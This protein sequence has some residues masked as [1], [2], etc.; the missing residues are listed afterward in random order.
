MEIVL[1]ILILVV[2]FVLLIKG[3][4]ILV[5][6]ASSI[7]SN[8]KVSKMLIGL[9]IVAFGTSAPELAISISSLISGET[10]MLLG[11]VIGSNILNILLLIGVAALICPLV[12]R[13]ATV[14]KELP[15]LLLI[16]TALAVLFLDVVIDKANN[17]AITRSDGI[18]CILFF[19]IFLYYLIAMAK[20][21]KTKSKAKN[22][23]KTEEEKPKYN[24]WISILL[25]VGGLV[26]VI[27]GS[28]LV[29][30]SASNIATAIGISERVIAL[31][32]VAFGT[33]LPEL[34][35]TITAARR[36]EQDLI[37]GNII[38][39]NIFN[40]CV[41]LGIPVALFGTVTP[42]SFQT[43]DLIMFIGSAVLLFLFARTDRK[44]TKLEG[45]LMLI[46][47]AIYYGFVIVGEFV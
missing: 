30:D 11:N 19:G 17:N 43:I 13:S 25:T 29:V 18:I 32:I 1:Q 3:A 31:T 22:A 14:R 6:G 47:F 5:S 15:M 37:V 10:D 24:I 45:T 12:I 23:K 4:D 42:D 36:R 8:F 33:S 35:T 40:I 9:T 27:F 7:A 28:R 21:K 39:S 16:T 34:V 38:G 46:A 41:V 20:G 44:I 26:G 2:G